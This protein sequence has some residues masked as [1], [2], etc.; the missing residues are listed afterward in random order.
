MYG[1]EIIIQLVSPAPM[2]FIVGNSEDITNM[3]TKA[4]IQSLSD[5]FATKGL[6]MGV[7]RYNPISIYRYHMCAQDCPLTKCT[8]PLIIPP[9]IA[10]ICFNHTHRQAEYQQCQSYAFHIFAQ[11]QRE[12]DLLGRIQKQSSGNH[13]KNWH[14]KLH[15]IFM[16]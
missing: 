13:H 16:A 6:M 1:V 12:T 2:A 10:K 4:A 15:A 9:R 8:I 11:Q 7:I 14:T 3:R 5:A